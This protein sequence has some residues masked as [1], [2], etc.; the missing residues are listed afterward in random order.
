MVKITI[1]NIANLNKILNIIGI[2]TISLLARTN[3][4]Q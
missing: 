1:K 4:K 3:I 2:C